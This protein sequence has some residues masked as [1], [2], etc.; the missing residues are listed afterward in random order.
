M[1][2]FKIKNLFGNCQNCH[3]N[4][5]VTQTGVT[6]SGEACAVKEGQYGDEPLIVILMDIESI[7]VTIRKYETVMMVDNNFL[8]SYWAT[9]TTQTLES[10]DRHSTDKI[11]KKQ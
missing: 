5:G 10:V 3:C 7:N 8:V 9:L 11:N 2:L 4:R 1:T 6:V